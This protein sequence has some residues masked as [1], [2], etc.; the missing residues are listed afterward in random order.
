MPC[1][2]EISRKCYAEAVDL[3]MYNYTALYIEHQFI[4]CFE[5]ELTACDFPIARHIAATMEAFKKK[6]QKKH[7][8]F[9]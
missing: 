3:W 9:K 8:L 7:G 6:V 5:K 4:E 1:A 2:G